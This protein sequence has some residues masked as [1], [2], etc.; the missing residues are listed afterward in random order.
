TPLMAPGS[1]LLVFQVLPNSE[2]AADYLP[3]KVE[4]TYPHALE[5]SFSEDE[6]EPGDEISINVSADGQSKVGLAAVDKSVFILAENRLN[7]QQVFAELERLYMDPQAELHEVNIYPVIE[8]KGAAEVFEDA[9]VVVLSNHDVPQGQQYEWTGQEGFWDGLMRL[10]NKGGMMVEEA[11][12]AMDEAGAMPPQAA[13]GMDDSSGEGLVEVE[14]VRQYFPETWL[15]E[16]IETDS[17]GNASLDVTVPDTITTWMLRAVG[18]SKNSGLGIAEAELRAFQPFFLKIDL[19]YAAIRGEEFPVSV[20]I[21]NYLDAEQEIRVEIED[22]DWFDLLD[23]AV[24][25]VRIGPNELG[26]AEFTI[27]PTELGVN[28]VEVKAQ[29][30]KA[31]DAMSK[32]IIVEPEGVSREVV[33]NLVLS[34]GDV[35]NI[36]TFIP[37]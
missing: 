1:R 7:L 14:R 33:D 3:F 21:Y 23:N 28:A 16:D 22:S 37:P 4:G 32:T 25:T 30:Q 6:A 19:P 15:W 31:A 18:V 29:G 12:M 20:A 27:R 24:Q 17:S 8:T 35:E 11:E 9:G 10:F 26:S 34:D 5:V 13:P 36:G 2:V